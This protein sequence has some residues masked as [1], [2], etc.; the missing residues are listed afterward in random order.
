MKLIIISTVIV[1]TVVFLLGIF[2]QIMGYKFSNDIIGFWA[3][4]N[5]FNG[6]LVLLW[7]LMDYVCK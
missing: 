7:I 6:L 3:L 5:L 2:S 1:N 4:T